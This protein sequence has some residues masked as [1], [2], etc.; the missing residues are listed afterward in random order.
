[1][2]EGLVEGVSSQAQSFFDDL[3]EQLQNNPAVVYQRLLL[4]PWNDRRI[5]TE[6]DM[7][8]ARVIGQEAIARL[9]ELPKEKDDFVCHKH[10]CLASWCGCLE[11]YR[12]THCHCGMRLVSDGV[13]M[14]CP[15][16]EWQ[17]QTT[18]LDF[19]EQSGLLNLSRLS[20]MG[21]SVFL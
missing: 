3:V 1:M 19:T 13:N 12:R 4:A 15:M 17:I 6:Q 5:C 7:E 16:C 11:D 20:L 10:Q 18:Y 14:V 2:S 9:R 21:E 8:V